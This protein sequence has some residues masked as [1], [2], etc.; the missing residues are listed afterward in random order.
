MP[1]AQTVVQ[2]ALAAADV[3]A[4]LAHLRTRHP[5]SKLYAVGWSLGAGL[6]LNHMGEARPSL[7]LT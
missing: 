1:A 4:V 5:E 3:G 6:L 2:E 7:D